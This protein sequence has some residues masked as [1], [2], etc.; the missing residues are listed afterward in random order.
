MYPTKMYLFPSEISCVS[1]T[2]NLLFEPL[3]NCSWIQGMQFSVLVS[4]RVTQS[5]WRV[6][7]SALTFKD[8][9]LSLELLTLFRDLGI[10]KGFWEK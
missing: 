3:Q 6:E 1:M 5:T 9:V 2:A 8:F 4:R 10:F 7:T